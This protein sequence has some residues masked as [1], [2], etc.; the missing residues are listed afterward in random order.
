MTTNQSTDREDYI[1]AIEGLFSLRKFPHTIVPHCNDI[2][3]GKGKSIDHSPGNRQFRAIVNSYKLEYINSNTAEKKH[4]GN[5]VFKTLDS[6]NPPGRFLTK[7]TDETGAEVW[8]EVTKDQA[9]KKVRQALREGGPKMK[10]VLRQQRLGKFS[11][12]KNSR[13]K[14]T[15]KLD[16]TDDQLV[17]N[18]AKKNIDT[19]TPAVP[20]QL[21]HDWHQER[22]SQLN[23]T[24]SCNDALLHEGEKADSIFEDTC[25]QQRSSEEQIIRNS[26]DVLF[27]KGRRID[28]SPGNTQFRDIVNSYKLDYI[29]STTSEKHVYAKK[30]L[31]TIA[32]LDPPG[33]FLTKAIDETGAKIW[34]EVSKDQADKKVRQALREGGAAIKRRSKGCDGA[35][36]KKRRKRNS[37]GPAVQPVEK[38]YL[39][40]P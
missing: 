13:A 17:E 24:H 11:T 32:S 33:R 15:Q 40:V 19:I 28:F 34:V 30:V 38:E 22:N 21:V 10:R 39:V 2:L 31:D 4:I 37:D 3:F 12:N 1:A 16:I 18:T 5:M 26:N 27:G 7:V 8:A 23:N 20:F 14:P 6:L 29:T 36:S 9:D 35:S 25:H